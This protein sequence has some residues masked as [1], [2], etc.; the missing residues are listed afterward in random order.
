[1]RAA[2]AAARG[3]VTNTAVTMN[4]A[5]RIWM[6]YCSDAI[7][8]PTCI[9]LASMRA[10]P[11][12]M[13]S[14][15]VMF[16]IRNIAGSSSAISRLT[17][18]E[19]SVRSRLAASK[20]RLSCAPRSKARITRMPLKPSSS[21]RLRRS[22]LTCTCWNS[23]TA[24]HM[25]TKKTTARIGITAIS[26]IASSASCDSDSTTPP[27]AIIGAGTAMLSSISATCWTCVVSLVVRVISDAVL[28]WS[29]WCGDRRAACS[30]MRPRTT[31]PKPVATFAVT[32]L[33][34]TAHTV[35][36]VAITSIMAPIS[37]MRLV[38]PGTMP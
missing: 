32:K 8:A 14:T 21:T 26:T 30:K 18:I 3:S 20:R 13:I 31:R 35:P 24:F 1:M 10:P 34:A 23:G 7:I 29:N 12:Q 22:I 5:K 4:T 9:A 25:I 37:R 28:K 2:D 17:A 27:M 36:M 16:I 15:P 6:A 11:N 33:L 38:S 19:V